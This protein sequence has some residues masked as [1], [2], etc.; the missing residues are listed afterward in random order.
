[1]LN[2]Y[3]VMLYMSY[4]SKLNKLYRKFYLKYA[5]NFIMPP[6][7][8]FDERYAHNLLKSHDESRMFLSKLFDFLSECDLQFYNCGISFDLITKLFHKANVIIHHNKHDP[9][10]NS[11]MKPLKDMYE[12]FLIEVDK[13][14]KEDVPELVNKQRDVIYYDKNDLDKPG[15]Q[16]A[17]TIAPQPTHSYKLPE[18]FDKY[19]KDTKDMVGIPHADVEDQRETIVPKF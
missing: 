16:F 8:N 13:S 6:A 9:M 17:K 19:I 10:F 12:R 3:L 1:M 7:N 14:E 5:S 2:Y 18:H 11:Y 15:L 4:Q